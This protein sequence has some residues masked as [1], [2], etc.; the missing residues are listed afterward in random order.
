MKIL[1]YIS[2]IYQEVFRR[3]ISTKF[4]TGVE[5]VDKFGDKFLVID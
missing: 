2:P 5:V 1:G 4:C 3:G